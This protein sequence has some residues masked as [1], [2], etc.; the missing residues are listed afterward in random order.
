METTCESTSRSVQQLHVFLYFHS[1]NDIR[2]NEQVRLEMFDGAEIP[3]KMI[4]Q[5]SGETE[6]IIDEDFPED[7]KDPDFFTFYFF[8]VAHPIAVIFTAAHLVLHGV[9]VLGFILSL[10]VSFCCRPLINR[11]T[12]M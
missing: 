10:T 5:F 2:D 6:R 1:Y 7:R 4:P 11:M 9:P 3:L 8:A 12:L